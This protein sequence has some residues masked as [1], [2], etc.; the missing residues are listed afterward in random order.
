MNKRLVFNI[1]GK[2]MLVEAALIAPS[3]VVALIYGDGGGLALF[4][5]ILLLV[6]FGGPLVVMCK[7]ESTNL[8]AREGFVVVALI[9]F[10]LSFFGCLPFVFSGMIPRFADAFF[11]SVS[12][13]TTTGATV[14]TQIEGQMHALLFWRG[15]THWIGGMGVLVLTLAITPKMTGRTSHLIRAESP[16][17]SMSKLLP[18]MGDTAKL[19]Y[20]IYIVLTIAQIICLKLAGMGWFDSCLH[21]FSTAGTGGFSNKNAS[22]AS[23]DSALIDAIITIFM[24][25]FGINFALYFRIAVGEWRSAIKDEECITFL[26][27]IAIAVIIITINIMPV[28]G[29]DIAKAFRYASFQSTSIIS[30][31]GF[32]TADY[33]LWPPLSQAILMLLMFI[34]SC[35]GSTAGGVKVI[36][37]LLLAKSTKREVERTFMPR[38][39]SVIRLNGKTV[40]EEMLNQV[41]LFF[42]AYIALLI[43][44]TLVVCA[45]GQDFA[46]SFTA[47]LTTLSNVGPGLG[48]VGPMRNFASLSQPVKILLSFNMLAGRLEIFPLLVLLSPRVWSVS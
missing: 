38:R 7:P 48:G 13:F 40:E 27:I 36:R 33:E 23:Y 24:V 44:G 26:S 41:A 15:F 25:I 22:I 31:T 19:L 9:W 43:V 46:T 4:S 39:V 5:T 29:N 35:A 30:T 12:G 18:R 47:S 11:E 16:G 1:L 10:M 20:I 14:L 45:D 32:I 34:G 17:P 3:I 6:L 28:Y 21:A 2:L 37:V 8:R 42:F